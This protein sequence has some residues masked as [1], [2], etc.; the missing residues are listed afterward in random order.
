MV[1]KRAAKSNPVST[2]ITPSGIYLDV[3]PGSRPQWTQ[4]GMIIS[5]THTHTHT[6]THTHEDLH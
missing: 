5:N 6:N 1:K 4:G 3:V 2:N